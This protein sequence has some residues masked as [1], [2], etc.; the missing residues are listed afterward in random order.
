MPSLKKTECLR[1]F[2]TRASLRYP[3]FFD[4]RLV[5]GFYQLIANTDQI[6]LDQRSLKHLK[7]IL[8]MQFLLQ[9]RIENTLSSSEQA[10]REV[11]VRLLSVSSRIC[12]VLMLSYQRQSEI[13]NEGH[14]LQC[15]RT[16]LPGVRAASDSFFTWQCTKHAYL[17]CYLE[18]EKLRGY[19]LSLQDL[20]R[21]QG[22]L[23]KSILH[24][25]FTCCPATF[26]PY[27]HEE[28]CRQLLFLQKEIK[29]DNDLPQVSIHF[30]GQTP[31]DLEFLVHLVSPR[32]HVSMEKAVARLPSSIRFFPHVNASF[33]GAIEIEAFVFS[34]HIKTLCIDAYR[35]INLLHI[36][37]YL[38]TVL[39]DA[40]GLFRD[41]NGGLFTHQEDAFLKLKIE[42]SD[43]IAGFAH[44]GQPLFYALRPLEAQ[45]TLDKVKAETL[46]KAFSTILLEK[47]AFCI[48]HAP[49]EILIVKTQD[50]FSF[51]SLAKIK[52]LVNVT[53]A[54]LQISDA[55]YLV[56]IDP[57]T[58]YASQF[59]QELSSLKSQIK[60]R[61]L[62]L[63]F[64]NG[65]P[66]S[67]HPHYIASDLRCRMVYK[68]L[69]EG[70]TRLDEKGEALLAG[71]KEVFLSSDK[72]TYTFILRSNH[73]SNG[74]LVTAYHYERAWKQVFSLIDGIN[75]QA[76]LFIKNGEKILKGLSSAQG[77]GV[78]V[79]N[80]ETLEIQLEYA[81][82]DFLK[83]LSQPLFFPIYDQNKEPQVFNGPFILNFQNEKRWGLERNFYFWD[84]D[85]VYL[86]G[87]EISSVA[88]PMT[89]L[90]LYERGEL[91]WLGS[92][93]QNMSYESIDNFEKQELIHRRVSS[94]VLWLHLN[95]SSFPLHSK[96]IRQALSLVLDRE[97]IHQQILVGNALFT[98]LPPPFSLARQGTGQN[99][100]LAEEL[101][102]LGLKE[103]GLTRDTFPPLQLRVVDHPRM[104][105][106]AKY[107]QE[108]WQMFFG[109]SVSLHYAKWDEF[110][111]ALE[112][113]NFQIGGCYETPIYPDAFDMLERFESLSS[114]NMS[115]WTNP[116]FQEKISLIRKTSHVEQ[117]KLWIS[118]A[119]ELL[120]SEAPIIPISTEIQT[121]VHLSSLQ[122][123]VFD[124]TGCIDFRW[125]CFK[126]GQK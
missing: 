20:Q 75:M 14:I 5:K 38:V 44:F 13:F 80:A 26:W 42:L 73:W 4:E 35:T 60:K 100:V 86:D 107:L 96:S 22:E 78:R 45:I 112:K 102:A 61:K 125:A 41:F 10:G 64:Q 116:I 104:R 105:A 114:S 1:D 66:P 18:L 51:E 21:I 2:V 68:A 89:D 108:S 47:K 124:Y 59:A 54:Y 76:F 117:R 63:A 33:A 83:I 11:A 16:L 55:H 57:S 28:S 29:S 103:M 94:R 7:K 12:I 122:G 97:E 46:F 118:E 81:Y 91:D 77:F 67:L 17:F 53:Y 119:E 120:M 15:I 6:F 82:P 99:N 74:E 36:R 110:R 85:H 126:E 88:D 101:F 39:E 32:A 27:N 121:Y 113:G 40:I 90:Q 111:N 19:D 9:K 3:K 52:T 72:M 56:L 70:L 87:I 37:K 31:F 34:L 115:R 58:I 8:L 98:P 106:L 84:R 43:K 92:P 123:Y 49:Q 23:H 48:Q 109:I 71:A 30:K 69:F 65:F 79:L 24:E 93:L 62:Y 50:F 25:V 95:T